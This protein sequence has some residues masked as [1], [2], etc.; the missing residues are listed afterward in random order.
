MTRRSFVRWTGVIALAASAWWTGPLLGQEART[1]WD[2]VYTEA[3][4]ARGQDLVADHCASCHASNLLGSPGAPGI[5]GSE[6]LFVWNEEP[7]GELFSYARTQ[8]PPG[9]AGSLT[10]QEYADIVAAL[11][12]ASGFPAGDTELPGDAD[13]LSN[14]RILRQ[15]P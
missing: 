9:Q 11:L 14:I 6:F 8:M 4:L 2:G 1:T 15:Q 5:A 12:G 7:L 3:Q 10:P 13:V